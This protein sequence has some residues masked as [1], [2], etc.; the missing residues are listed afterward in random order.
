MAHDDEESG[1]STCP[2]C[3]ADMEWESCW[4][5]HGDGEFDLYDEDPVNFAEG[6]AFEKCEECDGLGGYLV[7]PEC[8]TTKR[9][10]GTP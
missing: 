8:T 10:A 2:T 7:C 4:V 6:V 9:K 1:P 3:G 5:C